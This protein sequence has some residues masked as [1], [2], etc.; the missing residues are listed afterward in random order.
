MTMKKSIHQ[1][2][3]FCAGP[4]C[5]CRYPAAPR[6]PTPYKAVPHADMENVVEILAYFPEIGQTCVVARAYGWGPRI[7]NAQGDE[8]RRLKGIRISQAHANAAFIQGACNSHA[9]L[10]EIAERAAEMECV[11][12]TEGESGCEHCCAVLALKIAKG[13]A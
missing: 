10:V 4:N 2:G 9:L 13:E 12:H 1:E 7:G 5:D 6:T 11:A 8:Y 3:K